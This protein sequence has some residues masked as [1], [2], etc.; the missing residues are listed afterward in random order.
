MGYRGSSSAAA[1][2]YKRSGHKIEDLFADLIGGTTDDLPLQ[3]KTDVIGP[4]DETY[5]VKSDSKKW[6]IFLYGLPRISEDENFADLA[7]RGFDLSKSLEA[8][9]DNPE[10]YFADKDALK[11][12]LPSLKKAY[13][14]DRDGLLRALHREFQHN[15]YLNSKE[16]LQA[17]NGKL[18]TSIKSQSIKA[19]FLQLALFNKVEVAYL[20]IEDKGEFHVFKASDVVSCLV[21]R[22]TA[23]VS[24][25]GGQA[26]DL[27]LGGQKL[28]LKT[29]VNLMELEVRN[30]PGHYRELR[31]N[32]VS[33]AC[34]RLLD[35]V[36][37]I[38]E[39][40]GRI[41]KRSRPTDSLPPTPKDIFG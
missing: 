1:S 37:L 35:D 33:Q 7:R 2:S 32:F 5:S 22:T 24:E 9:P 30:D 18:L 25:T 6:Q 29:D 31:M 40:S 16:T 21:E 39:S 38:R 41:H 15:S 10:I 26:G 3:G 34:F 17:H 8:F 11:L 23:H 36:F 4:Q 20:V 14:R 13:G 27:S 12:R 19:D 28:L